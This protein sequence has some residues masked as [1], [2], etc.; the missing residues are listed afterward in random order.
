VATANDWANKFNRAINPKARAYVVM[1]HTPVGFVYD[2]SD[3]VGDDLPIDLQSHFRAEGVLDQ[4]MINNAID[5]CHKKNIMVEYDK[6][7][8]L[9]LAGRAS[10]DKFNNTRRITINAQHSKEVQ[11]STLCHEIAHLMLGHLGEFTYCQC[12]ARTNLSKEVREIEAESVS[13]L[14]CDRL[15][16]KTD[17]ERY[18]NGYLRD[19]SL[20]EDISINNILITAGRIESMALKKECNVKKLKSKNVQ[21][22]LL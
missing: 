5:C 7:I 1:N 12:K 13:W 16:I 14:V 3:T 22:A 8:A 17:A 2:V 4:D 18:L 20:L 15:G 9:S 11:F 10:H 19:P 21:P 6:T